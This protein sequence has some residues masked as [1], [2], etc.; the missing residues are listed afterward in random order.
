[1]ADPLAYPPALQALIAALK[2]LPGIGPRSAERM[3]LWLLKPGNQAAAQLSH[4]I[5]SARETVRG[6][7]Q[8][9]FFTLDELC[10]LCAHPENRE[11]SV[12]VV[13]QASDILP[14]ERAGVFR[15]TYHSLGGKLSPLD[16]VGPESLRIAP[17]IE[18]IQLETVQEVILALSGDVEGEATAS[19]LTRLLHEHG[20]AV[21]RLAQGM[22]A[23]SSLES[24][25]PVTL[26]RA[27]EF[28][29]RATDSLKSPDTG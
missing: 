8:C 29:T 28:R 1:M 26:A 10:S 6:C 20:V 12:C 25:D 9:G 27:L 15:G 11:P 22:P 14:L 4:Q 18:R 24:A 16:K 19:Y 5:T 7:R 2:Q 23:G 21:S 3:A 13:E 17:L